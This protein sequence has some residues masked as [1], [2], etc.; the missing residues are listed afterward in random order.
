MKKFDL[1]RQSYESGANHDNNEQL[2]DPIVRM[3][4]SIANGGKRNDCKIK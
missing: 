4:F 3:K 1:H 2:R